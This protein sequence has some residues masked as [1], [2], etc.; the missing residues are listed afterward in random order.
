MDKR[1]TG[2]QIEID[3]LTKYMDYLWIRDKI[4][5]RCISM[6]LDYVSIH[7]KK[8]RPSHKGRSQKYKL[9]VVAA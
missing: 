1:L 2:I 3:T 5:T 7:Y 4:L 8:K 9:F 6:I